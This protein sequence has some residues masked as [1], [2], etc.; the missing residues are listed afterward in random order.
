VGL[1]LVSGIAL[2]T[3]PYS[4]SGTDSGSTPCFDDITK[5]ADVQFVHLKYNKGV[6]N[7]MDET[8]IGVHFSTAWNS[9]AASPKRPVLTRPGQD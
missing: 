3:V 1:G 4:G 9:P 5:Q 2:L 7:I 6:A 8:T